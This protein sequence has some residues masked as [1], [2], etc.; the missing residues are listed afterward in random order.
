MKKFKKTEVD[1]IHEWK[2]RYSFHHP[3]KVTY[4]LGS[5]Q[6]FS[7]TTD[8]AYELSKQLAI[9]VP[10]AIKMEKERSTQGIDPNGNKFNAYEAY[11]QGL[12]NKDE[13]DEAVKKYYFPK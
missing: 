2:D 9:A 1:V 13:L 7:L 4:S 6:N 3:I 5:K 8:E 10:K 11:V 12:I